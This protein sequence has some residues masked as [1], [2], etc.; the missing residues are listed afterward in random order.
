MRHRIAVYLGCIALVA[1][2]L[3]AADAIDADVSRFRHSVIEEGYMVVI[4]SV[5]SLRL[6]ARFEVGRDETGEFVTRVVTVNDG[7]GPVE[8]L[9]RTKSAEFL[10][11]FRTFD[12]GAKPKKKAPEYWCRAGAI[13]P[14]RIAFRARVD[15]SYRE[16]EAD[17]TLMPSLAD[18]LELIVSE[19]KE[20]NQMPV[21]MS[22]LRPAMA[23]R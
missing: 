18:F 20:A 9:P 2:R 19:A 5:P 7:Q 14:P 16:I 12:W 22:G 4:D 15:D 11:K 10:K 21:P 3:L 1:P 13:E 23:H 17:G 6:A 8:R